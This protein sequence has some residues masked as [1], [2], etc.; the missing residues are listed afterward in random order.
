[1]KRLFCIILIILT[2]CGC[3]TTANNI[4]PK[5]KGI[6]FEAEVSCYNEKY[7]CNAVI[8][9]NGDTVIEITSPED[10]R[11]L[12]F[13]FIANKLTIEYQGLEYKYNST[14][15]EHSVANFIYETLNSEQP[16]VV[17]NNDEFYTEG[18]TE[19]F[20]Y[21][22]FVG[23]TGLPLKICDISGGYE[24]IIKNATIN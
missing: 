9:Q 18:K 24:A 3:E 16:E 2:L 11:G 12:T 17:K 13:K 20:N 22:L 19:N 4:T 6:S 7:E 14:S 15:P 8:S 5:T 23:A 21:R 10:I 1:M